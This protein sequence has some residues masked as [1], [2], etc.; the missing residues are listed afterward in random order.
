M[1]QVSS[2][3]RNSQLFT[4]DDGRSRQ[5][6]IHSY[7]NNTLRN[8]LISTLKQACY[9]NGQFVRKEQEVRSTSLVGLLTHSDKR[10]VT[11][12]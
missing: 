8:Y 7:F 4:K 6:M 10:L 1:R 3:A 12:S 5:T 2:H 9:K 11:N